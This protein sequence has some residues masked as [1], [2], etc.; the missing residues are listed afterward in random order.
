MILRIGRGHIKPGTWN[1]FEDVYRNLLVDGEQPRGLRERWLVRDVD[2]EH[3]GFTVGLWDSS[4][5]LLDWVKSE[6]F[7]KIQ[8]QLKP[9][10]VGDYQVHTCEARLHERLTGDAPES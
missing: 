6:S 10:F 4:E 1:A 3:G 7:A 2:D 8:A 9:F 5:D